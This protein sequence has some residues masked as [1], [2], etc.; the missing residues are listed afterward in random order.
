M[1]KLDEYLLGDNDARAALHSAL[2]SSVKN[3]K[4]ASAG[5]VLKRTERRGMFVTL[6]RNELSSRGIFVSDRRYEYYSGRTHSTKKMR[7]GLKIN[8]PD[9]VRTLLS[10]ECWYDAGILAEHKGWRE[11]D[12]SIV[13]AIMNKVWDEINSEPDNSEESLSAL[14]NILLSMKMCVDDVKMLNTTL[15]NESKQT[16]NVLSKL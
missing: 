8:Q 3:Y 7:M 4:K 9:L 13:R 1:N 12:S 10:P 14:D 15:E 11:C 16:D 6:L 2:K 5:K